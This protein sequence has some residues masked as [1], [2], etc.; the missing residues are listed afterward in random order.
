MIVYEGNNV[1]TFTLASGKVVTLTE[2]ERKELEEAFNE[3]HKANAT[4]LALSQDEEL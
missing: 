1:Y 3:I 4:Y 2:Q